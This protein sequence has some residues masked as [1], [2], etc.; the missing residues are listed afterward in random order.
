L[1]LSLFSSLQKI[2]SRFCERAKPD[3]PAKT[4]PAKASAR[5]YLKICGLDDIKP[6]SELKGTTFYLFAALKKQTGWSRFCELLS[7]ENRR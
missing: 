3:F 1:H 6:P 5:I 7:D 2:C 4:S